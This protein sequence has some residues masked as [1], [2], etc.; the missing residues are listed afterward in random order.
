MWTDELVRNVIKSAH[1]ILA[2]G[3]HHKGALA[4]DREGS[5]VPVNSE[6]AYAF[7]E[8]GAVEHAICLATRL[9]PGMPE[10][11]DLELKVNDVINAANP[12]TQYDKYKA[13]DGNEHVTFSYNDGILTTEQVVARF[14][15]ALT[16]VDND[17]ELVKALSYNPVK[18]AK[19]KAHSFVEYD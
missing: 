9:E 6:A 8:W 18:G 13:A 19:A 12:S 7:C 14:E 16:M 1:D 2:S 3:H 5:V 11:R 4:V 17:P 10:F 15:N